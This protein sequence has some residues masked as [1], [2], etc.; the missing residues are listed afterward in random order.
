MSKFPETFV[1]L[2]KSSSEINCESF[3]SFC[4]VFHGYRA[5]KEPAFF[6]SSVQTVKFVNVKL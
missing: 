4:N 2:F 3:K 1:H 6:P 5:E